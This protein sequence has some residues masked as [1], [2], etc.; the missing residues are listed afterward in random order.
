MT[1]LHMRLFCLHVTLNGVSS[2]ESCFC[3]ETLVLV[4]FARLSKI[5][6]GYVERGLLWYC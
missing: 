3:I 6:Q 5:S 4:A 2:L 1:E